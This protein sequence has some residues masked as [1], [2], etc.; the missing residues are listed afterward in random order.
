MPKTLEE[1]I[2]KIGITH[3]VG[4]IKLG[5]GIANKLTWIVIVVVLVVGALGWEINNLYL[6]IAAISFIGLFSFYGFSSILKFAKQH[7]DAALLEGAEFLLYHGKLPL[8]AKTIPNP[9]KNEQMA[10]EEAGL[11]DTEEQE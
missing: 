3:S 10:I 9:P 7:P 5:R 4:R 11:E 8:S 1:I 2:N 6:T